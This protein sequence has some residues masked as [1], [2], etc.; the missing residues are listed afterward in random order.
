MPSLPRTHL[1][2]AVFIC[3]FID[4]VDGFSQKL[5]I[6]AK[7]A[8]I[9]YFTTFSLNAIILYNLLWYKLHSLRASSELDLFY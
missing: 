3:K 7:A 8:S 2:V 5:I 4:R 1:Q 9:L 6:L